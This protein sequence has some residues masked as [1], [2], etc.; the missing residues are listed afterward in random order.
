M[1]NITTAVYKILINVDKMSE[2]KMHM[3]HEKEINKW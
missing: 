3:E 2:E 1:S